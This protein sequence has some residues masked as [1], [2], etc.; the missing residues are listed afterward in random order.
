MPTQVPALAGGGVTAHPPP[1]GPVRVHSRCRIC[2]REGDNREILVP[3]LLY[4]SGQLLAYFQC[5]GC[6]ALNLANPPADM[7]RFYPTTYHGRLAETKSSRQATLF[8]IYAAAARWNVAGPLVDLVVFRRRSGVLR[9][10]LASNPRGARGASIVD[11]GCGTGGMLEQLAPLG[12]ARLEGVDPYT[13]ERTLL[14]GRLHIHRGEVEDLSGPFDYVM[15][16]HS[17]EHVSDPFRLLARIHER[18]APGGSVL[19]RTPMADSYAFREYGS[20]W[21]QIDPPRHI[22][23]HT[24]QSMRTLANRS[25]FQISEVIYDSGPAQ[26]W[27][28][29]LARRGVA[30]EEVR[31]WEAVRRNVPDIASKTS[32]RELERKSRELNRVGAGDQASFILHAPS[33]VPVPRDGGSA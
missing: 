33:A 30:Q 4:S 15:L 1:P 13:E 8:R 10:F 26:F 5:G 22:V 3:E 31:D 19:V 18:L 2:D 21:Y 27:R 9:T 24:L 12:F 32:L 23:V 20:L 14:A 29:E 17:I 6:G 11:V 16:N 25:G 28:S 7:S